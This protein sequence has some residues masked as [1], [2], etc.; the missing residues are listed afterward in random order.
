MASK[1]YG[2]VADMVVQAVVR[3]SPTKSLQNTACDILS[4][5]RECHSIL[6]TMQ[7]SP[8]LEGPTP[9]VPTMPLRVALEELSGS[10]HLL[11][12]RLYELR[13]IVGVL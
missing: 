3:E 9:N 2:Q 1:G 10:V 5:I 13:E 12:K 4:T 7:D 6:D 8:S 11:S